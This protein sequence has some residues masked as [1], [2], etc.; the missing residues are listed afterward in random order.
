MGSSPLPANFLEIAG[1]TGAQLGGGLANMAKQLTRALEQQTEEHK[2]DAAE[3]KLYESLFRTRPELSPMDP[4]EFKNLSAKDKV[5]VGRSIS[6]RLLLD[7]QQSA[8]DTRQASRAFMAKQG[9]AMD[10]NI[11]ERERQQR[12]A[13][14][15][16]GRLAGFND[17]LLNRLDPAHGP[18][19]PLRSDE[20]LG[21]LAGSGLAGQ[22]GTE[23]LLE[24]VLRSQPKPKQSVETVHVGDREF[25]VFPPGSTVVPVPKQGDEKAVPIVGEDGEILEYGTRDPKTGNLKPLRQTKTTA[26]SDGGDFLQWERTFGAL[27]DAIATE[28]FKI[29]RKMQGASPERLRALQ[30]RRAVAERE[31]AKRFGESAPAKPEAEPAPSSKPEETKQPEGKV[32]PTGVRGVWSPQRGLIPMGY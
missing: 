25:G 31:Y 32:K 24:V 15:L 2:Q 23:S 5:A 7:E 6:K 18:V 19:N 28:E 14:E 16:K 30:L 9:D 3:A 11:A 4:L 8:I 10:S 29:G 20:L 26:E 13:E 22:P 17:Q 12:Q 27:D 21:L 1:S